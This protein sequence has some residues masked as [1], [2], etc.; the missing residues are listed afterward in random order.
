MDALRQFASCSS[1]EGRRKEKEVW[2]RVMTYVQV[3]MGV[4][5]HVVGHVRGSNVDYGVPL[6]AQPDY[7][8]MEQPQYGMDNLWRFKWGSD[9]AAIFNTSLEYLGDRSLITEV[10]HFQEAGQIIAQIEEDIRQLGTHKWEA[11]CLQDASICLLKSANVMEW[12]D[13]VQVEWHMHA[14]KH[15]DA[16]ICCGHRS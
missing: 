2:V 8:T 4:D 9:D 13:R 15:V 10:H 1:K 7:D 6:H 5:P 16:T 14:I 12:L 11:G 3:D